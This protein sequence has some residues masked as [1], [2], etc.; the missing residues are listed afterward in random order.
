MFEDKTFEELMRMKLSRVQEFARKQGV[1]IDTRPPSLI[2]FALAGNSVEQTQAYMMLDFVLNES[3]ADTQ[4]RAFLI[5]RAAE[6]G[7]RPYGATAA[8][9]QGNFNIDI[10]IGSRFTLRQLNYTAL[11]QVQPGVFRMQCDT[12]GNLGNLESGILV[13]VDYIPGLKT[14]ELTDVLIPGED[15]ENT[16][17]FRQRYYESL[18]SQAFGGNIQDYVE[19]AMALQGVG[20]VK[21]YPVW[22]GGGTVKLVIISSQY[23]RPTLSLLDGVQTTFDPVFNQGEGLGLAPVGH[24]VTIEGVTET[25]VNV[26]SNF[27]FYAGWSWEAIETHLI[28]TIEQYFHEL[29]MQ[30]S[31]VNWREDKAATL[32]VRISQLESRFLALPGVLDVSGTRLNGV[33]QNLMLSATSIP[34]PGSVTYG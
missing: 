20:G 4:S 7:L 12:P 2:A 34:I 26:S 23:R 17:H 10:P 5:R 24:I 13:P 8:I 14:A 27:T 28:N 32:I 21:V 30:W 16:E 33:A 25:A 1:T 6:R 3:F 11:E 9:R 22:N 19:K 15:E 31:K 29:A 18:R